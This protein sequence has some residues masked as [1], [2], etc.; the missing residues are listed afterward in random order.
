MTLHQNFKDLF[1]KYN[2]DN[3]LQEN[4]WLEIETYYTSKKRHYHTLSHLENLFQELLSIQ[5]KF[6]NWETVQ[7]SIF[8]HDMIYNASRNDN[9]EKSAILAIE[10]LK[11]IGISEAEILKC[12]HQILMTKS[13]EI[14]DSDTNYFT[15]ADLSIL[16]KSWETYEEYFKQIRKEYRIYPD[17]MYNRGRKKALKHFLE[18][19]R[20]FKTDYFFEKYEKQARQNLKNEL[21]ILCK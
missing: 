15:D 6:E 9:E 13:H 7:F 14:S 18:M 16:G 20:I 5:E 2:Q 12:H 3:S 10:R 21:E 17:F 4:L 8:Y 1:Q 11:E 19:E